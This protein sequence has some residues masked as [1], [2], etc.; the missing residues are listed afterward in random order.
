MRLG[1][2]PTTK[3]HGAWGVGCRKL[4]AKPIGAPKQKGP[5]P[6]NGSFESYK[7]KTIQQPLRLPLQP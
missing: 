6:T 4:Y 7:A 5:V 2:A 1:G 3:L